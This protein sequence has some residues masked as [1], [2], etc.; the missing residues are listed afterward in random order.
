MVETGR[1]QGDQAGTAGNQALQ[2]RGA[3]IVIDKG[4]DHFVA[5]GQGC[6]V[7]GQA[8]RLKVQFK[9]IRCRGLG[10]AVLVIG[11]AAEKQYAHGVILSR[12]AESLTTGQ[13]HRLASDQPG[14]KRS[15][16]PGR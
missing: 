3:E 1:A 16:V 13:D 4:A 9:T 15:D 12:L 10:E 2:H 11:L 5:V 7:F 8:C 6:G 14:I